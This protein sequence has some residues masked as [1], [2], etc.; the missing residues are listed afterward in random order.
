MA[1]SKKGTGKTILVMIILGCIIFGGFYYVSN[2]EKEEPD[3]EEETE[4]DKML[5]LDLEKEYPPTA[6]EVIKYYARIVKTVHSGQVTDAQV[7]E[8]GK[9]ILQLYSDQ[10]LK[11]NPED[12]YMNKLKQEIEEYADAG[13]TVVSYSVDDADNAVK[14]TENEKEYTRILASFTMK[15]HVGYS[16]SCEEFVLEK[17]SDQQWKIVGWRLA[18]KEDIK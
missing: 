5:D 10:L 14:W 16:Q 7:N 3:Q 12:A 13:R 6:R 4:I 1:G 18:D 9:T 8:L 2:L 15:D 11:E 17:N